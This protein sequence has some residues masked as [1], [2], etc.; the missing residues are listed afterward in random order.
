[1][2]N[3]YAQSF[4]IAARGEKAAQQGAAKPIRRKV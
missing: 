2:F 4:L 3:I 1:M